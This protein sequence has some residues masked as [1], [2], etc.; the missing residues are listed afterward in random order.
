MKPLFNFCAI[1][2]FGFLLF[3]CYTHVG[4]SFDHEAET[5]KILAMRTA[6]IRLL[7]TKD[8]TLYEKAFPCLDTL[9]SIGEGEIRIE[10]INKP[11]ARIQAGLPDGMRF[12]KIE[13]LSDPAV[14]FSPDGKM[15]YLTG[16]GKFYLEITDSTGNKINRSFTDS[17]ISVFEKQGNCWSRKVI[18]KTY[19]FQ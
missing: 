3:S 13:L 11:G 15:A 10:T 6:N 14:K 18:A 19:N 7:P 12:T 16:Q 5:Q 17:E 1:V 4:N 2:I 9:I 8:S